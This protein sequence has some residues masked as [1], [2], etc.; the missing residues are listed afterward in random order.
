VPTQIEAAAAVRLEMAFLPFH[1][2]VRPHG[3]ATIKESKMNTHGILVFPSPGD[4][5]GPARE[6]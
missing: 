5:I 6:D 2:P 1:L 3:A 4:F